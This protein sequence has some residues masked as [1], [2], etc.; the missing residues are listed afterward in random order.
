MCK[1][2]DGPGGENL[3]Y[4]VGTFVISID[5]GSEIKMF[6]GRQVGSP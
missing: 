4:V 2:R 1:R 6:V 5:A 3:R